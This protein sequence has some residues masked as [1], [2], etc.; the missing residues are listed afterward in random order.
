MFNLGLKTCL[1]STS[2][3]TVWSIS[4]SRA[5]EQ[6]CQDKTNKK[7]DHHLVNLQSLESSDKVLVNNKDFQIAIQLRPLYLS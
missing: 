3:E 5:S 4:E 2:L 6:L 1:S 7:K